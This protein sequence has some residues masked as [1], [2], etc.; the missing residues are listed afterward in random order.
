MP[1]LFLGEIY[2][3]VEFAVVVGVGAEKIVCEDEPP[4]FKLKLLPALPLVLPDWLAVPAA[5]VEGVVK[6]LGAATVAVLPAIE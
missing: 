1:P 2:A 6:A 4:R 3:G 5:L